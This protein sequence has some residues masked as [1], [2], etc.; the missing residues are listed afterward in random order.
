MLIELQVY[1]EE[2][3]LKITLKFKNSKETFC[4]KKDKSCMHRATIAQA[5][6]L[7]SNY[8]ICSNSKNIKRNFVQEIKNQIK[9][10]FASFFV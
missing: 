6:N 7:L 1:M 4:I 2:E 3:I 10:R 5:S 8:I 9:M